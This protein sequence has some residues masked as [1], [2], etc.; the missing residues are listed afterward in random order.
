MSVD[1]D[2]RAPRLRARTPRAHAP[3]PRPPTDAAGSRRARRRSRTARRGARGSARAEPSGR[4]ADAARAARRAGRAQRARTRAPTT[5]SRPSPR[6]ATGATIPIA[7]EHRLLEADRSAAPRSAGE[8]GRCG[9]RE[10]VPRHRQSAREREYRDEQPERPVDEQRR[11]EQRGGD[12]DADS[13]GAA[14][15]ASPTTSDQRPTPIRSADGEHLR[16]GDHE[17][18]LAL[19]EPVLVVQEEHAEADHGDLRVQVDAAPEAEPPEPPVAQRPRD[20]VGLHDVDVPR[21]RAR[22]GRSLP[23]ERQR[24]SRQREEERRLGSSAP[25]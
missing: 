9:E 19:G 7:G 5:P 17:R 8:L 22:G 10:P 14:R 6:R 13:S 25:W 12:R 24:H 15:R 20:R 23:R 11:D 16:G 1:L 2:A 4:A 21:A 18:G 3:R